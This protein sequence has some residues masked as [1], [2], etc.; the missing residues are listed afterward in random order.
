MQLANVCSSDLLFGNAAVKEPLVALLQL[1]RK[2]VRQWYPK[3]NAGLFFER[4]ASEWEGVE[5]L[6]NRECASGGG[7]GLDWWQ[8]EGVVALRCCTG[9]TGRG[10]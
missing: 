7:R 3:S 8:R 4:F 6:Q 10:R 2:C 5:G 1:E 9:E